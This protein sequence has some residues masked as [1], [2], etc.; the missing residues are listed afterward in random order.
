MPRL[1]GK[2]AIVT[3]AASGIG[4]AMA[5]ALAAEGASVLAADVSES[6]LADTVEQV[7]QAGGEMESR[8]VDVS[9]SDD[10]KRAVDDAVAR[11]GR[12]T[13]ICSNA[14]VSYPG[15]VLDA[16]VEE[17]DRTMQVNLRGPFLGAKHAI[18]AMREA[19]GGSIINTGSANSVMAERCLTT[20][21]ASK[22]GVLMLTKAIAL[23][24]AAENIRCNVICPGFV[25]TPIN[26]PHYERLGGIDAVRASLPEWIPMG[27]GG[28]PSE[29][30][31]TAVFL[32]S[33]E[34]SYI[35][36]TSFLVDGGVT[37][38]L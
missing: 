22:G 24:F 11:F 12:L 13:T 1:Q 35:T 32:A 36:G 5:V 31:Q 26:I 34:S 38:G 37:A 33:D 3:G 8:H 19:G 28:E 14:G 10:V 20:Y 7:R 16:T 9:V 25:D 18:P 15:T 29:I 27:R 6:G 4:R 21:C 2:V 30:A 23:D 17:F